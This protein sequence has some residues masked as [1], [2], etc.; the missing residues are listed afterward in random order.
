[1]YAETVHA[2][3]EA[4][5]WP[6]VAQIHRILGV[7][8]IECFPHGDENGVLVRVHQGGEGRKLT[9][10]FRGPRDSEYPF[11]WRVRAV[12]PDGQATHDELVEPRNVVPHL[13]RVLSKAYF[14]GLA[15]E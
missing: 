10:E 15:L 8:R 12:T 13:E 7:E 4:F 9:H 1:M 3:S 5:Q 14:G 2:L 11:G 6:Q